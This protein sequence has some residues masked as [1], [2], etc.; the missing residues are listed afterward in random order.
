MLFHC[1]LPRLKVSFPYVNSTLVQ[2]APISRSDGLSS[3]RR[4]FF[5][6]AGCADGKDGKDSKD[7]KDDTAKDRDDETEVTELSSV[8]SS[9]DEEMKPTRLMRMIRSKRKTGRR[10]RRY[11]CPTVPVDPAVLRTDDGPDILVLPTTGTFGVK[12]TLT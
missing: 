10:L 5:G 12:G 2:E 4:R 11:A 6:G 7:K 9:R 3:F 1:K 8:G